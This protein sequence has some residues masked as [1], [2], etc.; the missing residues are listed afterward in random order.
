MSKL[1]P[2]PVMLRAFRRKDAAFDGTFFVAVK[3]TGVFCRPV[4][5]AKP[6]LPQN[7]EFFAAA[8][9][10]VRN[11]YRAC[12]LCRPLEPVPRP[13]AGVARLLELVEA[14]PSTPLR[15]RD[16][17]SLGIDA[18]TARRQFRAHCG[19]TFS[20]YQRAFRLGEALHLVRRGTPAVVAR[21][22]AGFESASGF[23]GALGRL[24]GPRVQAVAEPLVYTMIP[25]PLGR[26]TAVA[27]DTGV[28]LLDF[29]DRDGLDA[30]L[31]TVARDA[32]AV[33]VPGRHPHLRDLAAQLNAYF[34]GTLREFTVP[35]DPRG[36][37]FQR[38][39]WDYLRT[40]PYGQTRTYGQQAAAIGR[41]GA[42][43][44]VG[45]ANGSNPLSII[46]P[47]HRVV[48]A[49][50]ALTGYGGGTARKRWLLNHEAGAAR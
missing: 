17:R 16:L 48:G 10:A 44:A 6:P 20:K 26:M 25:T 47:C 33:L 35:L 11:G 41:P 42:A 27:H 4:C 46:V 3:T 34:R 24:A 49:G 15:E 45:R 43:R 19:T 12:K 7:V 50:G 30:A 31:R 13:P 2:V 14:D 1:P 36:T 28:V 37:P 39:V 18:A 23:R 8:E 40:I 38:R 5:R 32:G 29:A 9:D 22:A 21:G